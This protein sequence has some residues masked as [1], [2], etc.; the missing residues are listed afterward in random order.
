MEAV[1][2]VALPVFAIILAGYAAGRIGLLGRAA[3]E[4]L[5]RFVYWIALPPL[6]F[7][8]MAGAPIGQA[9]HGPFIGAYLGGLLAVWA[10]GS[11]LGRLIHREGPAVAVM[12]GMTASFSNTGY[13]G[14]PLFAAAFGE[15][16]LAPASLATV[17]MS[18]VAVGIAV[19]ALEVDRS[20]RRL[21]G[22]LRDAALALA[23]NPLVVSP[24]AGILVSLAGLTVPLPLERL[25][26][27]MGAAA[28]PCALFAIGLFLAG[29]RIGGDLA[30]VGWIGVLKLAWQP[31]ITYILAVTLFPMEPFWQ[32][33]AV[34][35]AALPTGALTF[36]VAQRYGVYVHRTSAAILVSTVLSVITLSVL[37]AAYAPRFGPG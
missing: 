6:L 2:T 35:L 18:A 22:A 13:M 1:V 3:S 34:L 11:A 30:E 7:L 19:V 33:S 23:R 8:A 24:V 10:I 21:A 27:L 9:I 29:Q 31:L 25:F 32:A 4:T 16:G 37:L 14:I 15:R 5:N 26:D 28:S 12:Q 17:I 20:R 36:V